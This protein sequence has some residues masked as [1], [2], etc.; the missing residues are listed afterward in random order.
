MSSGN[1]IY[2][3]SPIT[4]NQGLSIQHI[5]ISVS[6]FS[7]S[8]KGILSYLRNAIKLRIHLS[9]NKYDIIHA[10]YSST[11]FAAT[12]AGSGPMVVSLMGSDSKTG[13][14]PRF[15]IKLLNKYYWKHCI[16]KSEDMRISL[17]I[18]NVSII[19]N[20]VDFERFKPTD[21]ITSQDKLG[22]SISKK[23]ILFAAKVSRP[24]KNFKLSEHAYSFLRSRNIELHTLED[25]SPNQIPVWLNAADVVFLTSL[26]EG[27]PN[28]IKEAMACNKPIVSTDVGDVK[29]LFGKMPG[30]FLTSF[31]AEDVSDKIN[32]A[33]KFGAEQKQ[34]KGRKRIIELG[35]DSTTIANRIVD[36]YK[37]D[38]Q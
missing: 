25:I 33:L 32:L 21:K 16:V 24:E 4:R 20:G 8:G 38:I 19:P 15:A 34:T 18:E 30:H 12:I 26:W 35:L 11:A 36:V 23:H 9:K 1:T 5:G 27:S 3:I 13:K 22:W 29:W 31:D 37:Q 14:G 10:H 7:L 17:G 6:Y 2:G 28:V